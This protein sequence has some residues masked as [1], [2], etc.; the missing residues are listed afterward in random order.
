MNLQQIAPA[1]FQVPDDERVVVIEQSH[2]RELKDG[3][4]DYWIRVTVHPEGKQISIAVSAKEGR[5]EALSY[6]T[7]TVEDVRKLNQ[8][9][10]DAVKL[11][12]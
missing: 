8:H 5:K 3:V 11:A 7:L 10:L 12:E 1:H 6:L 4:K 2:R 9:L